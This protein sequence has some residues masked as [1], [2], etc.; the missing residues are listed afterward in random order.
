[1]IRTVLGERMPEEVVSCTL[2]K[3]MSTS[4][5]R[6]PPSLFLRSVWTLGEY[7]PQNPH[8]ILHKVPARSLPLP[9]EH[10]ARAT[11]CWSTLERTSYGQWHPCPNDTSARK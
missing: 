1:M 7:T 11:A 5:E 10:A 3:A 9:T 8:P 6:I 2:W 4:A